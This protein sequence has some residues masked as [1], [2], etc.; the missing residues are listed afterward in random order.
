MVSIVIVVIASLYIVKVKVDKQLEEKFQKHE[1]DYDLFKKRKSRLRSE[2]TTVDSLSEEVEKSKSKLLKNY[3]EI[4]DISLDSSELYSDVTTSTD[5]LSLSFLSTYSDSLASFLKEFA[6]KVDEK[7]NLFIN[8]PVVAPIAYTDDFTQERGFGLDKDP[9]TGRQ[10][11]HNGLD[12]AAEEGTPVIA[13]ANGVVKE[14][15]EHR[16]WGK[17]VSITHNKGII[18]YYAHLGSIT[19][20]QGQKVKK[21]TSIGTVGK[22]GLSTGPHVHYEIHF[23]GEPIDPAKYL[24]LKRAR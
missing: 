13:T 12:F 15:E 22:T 20:K 17:R 14:V 6:G 2:I 11:A 4:Q 8:L 10:T 7:G 18:T 1:S 16:F 3:R 23:D 21:G 5:S 9:F 19:V 24:L